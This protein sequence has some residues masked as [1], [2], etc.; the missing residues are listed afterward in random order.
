MNGPF[1]EMFVKLSADSKE[2]D[3]K[4]KEA[5]EGANDFASSFVGV[6]GKAAKAGLAAFGAA[7]AAVLAFGK[8]AVS[9]YGEYEQLVGGVQKLYGNAG[10]SLEEYAQHVGSSVDEVRDEWTKLEEAQ[11][12]VIKNAENAFL[13]SGMS[14]NEYMETA[15]SFSASLIKSLGGDTQEA[16]RI[17]D[18]AM[19]AMSDNVNT[20]GT[21]AEAVSNAFMGLSR[22]NYMMLDNLKLGY[23]GTA[24]GMMELINDSGI[25]GYT[26]TDTSQLAEVG[27]DKMILAIQEVQKQQGI[28]GTTAR[29][30]LHT[31][32]GS[33]TATR[34]AWE[35]IITAIG[36]GEGL[37]GAIEGMMT[38]LFGDESGGGLL[39]NIIPRIQTVMEGI[40]SFVAQAGP[41]IAERIPELVLSVFPALFKATTSLVMTLGRA[42]PELVSKIFPFLMES[43]L[44][45]MDKLSQGF[46]TGIPE[47]LAQ[48]LPALLAFTEEL[49]TNF[50][51]IVDA[52]ID[53]ILNLVDGLIAG[54]PDLIAYVPTIITNICGL[55][56]DNLPKV[57]GMGMEIIGSL[58]M[59]LGQNLPNLLANMGNIMMAAWN[60][61]TAINWVSLGSQVLGWIVNGIKSIG[62]SI[63]S[64]MKELAQSGW[65]AFKSIDW[66]GVGS[67]IVNGIVNGIKTF[68]D[69]V[70]NALMGMA[71]NAWK[72]VKNFF[73]IESPSK[74]MRDTI[75]R[76]IPEGM[77]IGIEANSDEVYDAMNDLNKLAIDPFEKSSLNMNSEIPSA[78][79]FGGVTINVYPSEGMDEEELARMVSNR[80]ND[81]LLRKIG[82]F[83]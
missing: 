3:A 67:A 46:V 35:N 36:R 28:A 44:E 12:T 45:L 59:G 57:L 82:V 1:L 4:M 51:E 81:E 70:K 7:S 38:A 63:P 69:A 72:S 8:Q 52:G 56:N 22:Q 43:G 53:L 24:S 5:K 68:G 33:A 32:E 71:E 79:S 39:S 25:L 27:F 83:A 21:D 77:A 20:F 55:I 16:A 74:L 62:S 75:G 37:D 30:A 40:G 64:I 26:L 58:I 78:R 19:Q 65:D 15:T 48:A 76:Y 60:V 31:I 49:R 73:G 23:A 50:G 61:I 11:N 13:T 10:M 41:I 17:T 47:F 42:I 34:K 66:A 18:I 29:E 14:M 54:L 80:I 2:Y 9:A 6:M